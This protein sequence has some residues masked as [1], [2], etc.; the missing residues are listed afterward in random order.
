M[1]LYPIHSKLHVLNGQYV[2]YSPKALR[3]LKDR[4]IITS[5]FYGLHDHEINQ[6]VLI[7]LV[8]LFL[9]VNSVD[10]LTL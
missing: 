4:N 7:E 10:E 8:T 1:K 2:S 3:K 5:T 9:C 6:N